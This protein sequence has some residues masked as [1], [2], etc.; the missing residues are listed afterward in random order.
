MNYIDIKTHIFHTLDLKP[1]EIKILA[2]TF[3]DM[4]S[5]GKY[6]LTYGDLHTMLQDS[7]GKRFIKKLRPTYFISD[8]SAKECGVS[9]PVI[10]DY[11]DMSDEAFNKILVGIL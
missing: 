1:K 11:A 6:K 9:T 3:I 4:V 8:S 10:C 5:L 7:L 2:N